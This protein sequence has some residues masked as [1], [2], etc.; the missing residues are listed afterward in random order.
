MW[1]VTRAQFTVDAC[2][3][4]RAPITRNSILSGLH[5]LTN[6][7][8]DIAPAKSAGS[9]LYANVAKGPANPLR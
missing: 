9:R 5:A 8:L 7:L 4:T 3:D 6:A 1:A 2:G